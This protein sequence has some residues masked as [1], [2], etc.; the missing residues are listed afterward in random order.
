MEQ[1]RDRYG[2]FSKGMFNL[3]TCAMCYHYL[4]QDKME[5]RVNWPHGHTLTAGNSSESSIIIYP[6]IYNH[7]VTSLVCKTL[8]TRDCNRWTECCKAA[9][10]CCEKQLHERLPA[11]IGDDSCPRT[12][13]GFSCVDAAKKRTTVYLACPSYI[14]QRSAMGRAEKI[15]DGNGSWFRE[16]ENGLEWTDYT[17][18]VNLEGYKLLYNVVIICNVISLLLLLPGCLIFIGFRHLRQ[19]HRVR[20]HLNLFISFLLRNIV[21][22]LWDNLV[23][24]D[25]LE[26]RAAETFM[27][28]NTISC[29]ILYI[30]TRYSLAV[31]FCWMFLEGFHLHRLIVSAFKIPSTIQSY[32]FCGW[33]APMLAVSVY[34]TIRIHRKDKGCWVENAGSFEWVLYTPNLICIIANV[35]FLCGILRILLSQLQSHPNEPSNFR[36]ALKASI[37]LVPLFGLQLFLVIYRPVP[38]SYY[39]FLFE[40][41]AAVITNS[42]G[43]IIALWLC[44]FNKEV[45]QKVRAHIPYFKKR[46]GYRHDEVRSGFNRNIHPEADENC[47]ETCG[48]RTSKMLL[49]NNPQ[50]SEMLQLQTFKSGY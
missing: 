10:K 15:C 14:E 3:W 25:R 48:L 32:Y 35:F 41:V 28:Q 9:A 45:H 27:H 6:D 17:K 7:S 37:V 42:Q 23:Y 19:Q 2:E 50:P 18:C 38:E 11:K 43:A 16:P 46:N 26:N 21:Y 36:R 12:W 13:D 29:K 40:I 49:H 24:N 34:S 1:C 44:Y 30:L 5:L 31:N 33:L 20:I 8:D 39:S 22:I 47:Q 4:F